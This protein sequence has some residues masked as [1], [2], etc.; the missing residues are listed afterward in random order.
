MCVIGVGPEF[1]YG[2]ACLLYEDIRSDFM[3]IQPIVQGACA[4]ACC[5][6]AKSVPARAAVGGVVR[7]VGSCALCS[8]AVEQHQTYCLLAVVTQ[9]MLSHFDQAKRFADVL[10]FGNQSCLVLDLPVQ[11][12]HTSIAFAGSVVRRARCDLGGPQT[13]SSLTEFTTFAAWRQ[14]WWASSPWTFTASLSATCSRS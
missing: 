8:V 5:V 1:M 4:R 6:R 14:S 3:R 13:V 11:V 2:V 10:F 9:D 7:N 12:L